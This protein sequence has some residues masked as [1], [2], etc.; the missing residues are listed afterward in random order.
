M[1]PTNF[2]ALSQARGADLEYLSGHSTF[3]AAGAEILKRFTGSDS[4]SPFP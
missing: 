3:S 1:P 4:A 2:W